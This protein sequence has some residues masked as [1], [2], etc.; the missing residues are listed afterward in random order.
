MW[1][2]ILTTS[3]P[4]GDGTFDILIATRDSYATHDE[5]HDAVRRE[6][7]RRVKNRRERERYI[8]T[9]MV[10]GT[11]DMRLPGQTGAVGMYMHRDEEDKM[12]GARDFIA[13]SLGVHGVT[14]V[15]EDRG[16]GVIAIQLI[17]PS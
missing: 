14:P 1:T 8:A 9:W 11:H 6:I 10:A 7:E 3:R 4:N 12:A 17:L 16:D 2:W 5:C 15:F 13:A